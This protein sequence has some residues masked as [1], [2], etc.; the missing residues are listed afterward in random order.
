MILFFIEKAEKV[1][2]VNISVTSPP[3]PQ[4]VDY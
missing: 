4:V 2:D 1:F 3:C